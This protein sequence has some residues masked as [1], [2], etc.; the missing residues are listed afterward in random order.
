MAVIKDY[1]QGSCHIIVH[2]DYIQSPEEVKKIISR[3]SNLVIN[4]E[5]RRVM[6]AKEADIGVVTEDTED[7]ETTPA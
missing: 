4:E 2:D 6:A 5:F 1:M 7:K 3:V